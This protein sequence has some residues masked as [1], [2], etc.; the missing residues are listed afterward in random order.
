MQSDIFE[1]YT[2]SLILAW[3]FS[4]PLICACIVL[5]PAIFLKCEGVPRYFSVWCGI[6]LLL[7][8]PI[9]YIVFLL[10]LSLSYCMQSLWADATCLFILPFYYPF[11]FVLLLLVGLSLPF[12]LVSVY[13]D[14]PERRTLGLRVLVSIAMPIACIVSTHLFFWVLPYAGKTV[15]WLNVKDVI[16]ATN[17]PP[18]V[19]FKYFSAPF[20]PLPVPGFYE[21]TPQQDVDLL[22]CHVATLYVSDKKKGFFLEQQYP[23]IYERINTTED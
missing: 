12:C 15:G 11:V 19:I 18:A 7:L 4:V 13:W 14:K 23:S 3:V 17:G 22:R 16:R 9:R 8:S 10:A 1:S 20:T 6:C 21:D 5:I 2:V